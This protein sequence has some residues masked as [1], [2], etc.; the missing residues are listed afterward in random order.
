M[1]GCLFWPEE[2]GVNWADYRGIARWL[3]RIRAEPGW[4]DPYQLMPGHP[5]P[6]PGP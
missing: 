4:V 2:F 6:V 1:C 5:L 3:E